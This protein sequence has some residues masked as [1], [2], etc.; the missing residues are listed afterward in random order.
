MIPFGLKNAL[1]EFQHIINDILNDYFEFS[2]VYI[3]DV[4]IYSKKLDQHFKHLKTFFN[5]IK[6][7]GLAVSAPKMKLF[8]TKIQ[9]LG[10]DIFTST[11]KPI[12]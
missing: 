11:I 10:H 7:N 8:Q 6:R 12:Q 3:D 9:F 4:L 1:S 2:I 5:V